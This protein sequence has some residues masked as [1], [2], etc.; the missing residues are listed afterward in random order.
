MKKIT[1]LFYENS[2]GTKPVRV[3]LLSLD[4][5]DRKLKIRQVEAEYALHAFTIWDK[6]EDKIKY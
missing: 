2:N 4:K 3:W 6:K 1:S 5:E